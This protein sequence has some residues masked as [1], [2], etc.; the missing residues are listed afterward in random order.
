MI[1]LD[2]SVLIDYFRNQENRAT[3]NL[4]DI[5]EANIPHGICNLVYQELLQ[6]SKTD[7]EFAQLKEYLGSLP[8]YSLLQGTASYEEAARI[9]FSCKRSGITVRSTI[10]TLICQIAIENELY[11]LHNDHDFTRIASIHPQLR[12]YKR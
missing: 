8:F 2:T 9:H 1:L 11:L 10:D 4:D 5:I 7:A 12:I 3:Q 6:G